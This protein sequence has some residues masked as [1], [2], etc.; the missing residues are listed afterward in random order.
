FEL[1][2]ENNSAKMRFNLLKGKEKVSGYKINISKSIL[3]PIAFEAKYLKSLT[4]FPFTISNSFQY[5]GINIAKEMSDKKTSKLGQTTSTF[6]IK[7]GPH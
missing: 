1:Y 6:K 4:S 5:L 3:F 7:L 2:F